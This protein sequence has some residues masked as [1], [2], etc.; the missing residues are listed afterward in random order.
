[1]R[2]FVAL[3]PPAEV[4]EELRERTC[5]LREL[6]PDLRWSRPEQWHLTLAFLGEVP[7]TSMDEL[8]TR[9]GRAAGRHPSL[10]LAFTG[11]GRFGSRVLWTKVQGD[12]A[13][14]CR[15]ADS[16]RAGARRTGLAV[17]DR[18]Y[19][20]HLTLARADG[21]P[22]LRPLVIELGSYEGRRWVADRMHLMRSRLGAGPGGTALHESVAGWPLT[23]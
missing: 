8:T 6:A 22:D 11:G 7:E 13:G 19:R 9:L 20:P 4:I 3:T 17:E 2:L 5:E 15:L 21:S 18:P 1:M 12:R 10:S 14:L 23:G 16:V